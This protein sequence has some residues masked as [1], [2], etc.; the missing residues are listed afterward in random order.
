MAK[1]AKLLV[2]ELEGESIVL[3]EAARAAVE[4]T[5]E[6]VASVYGEQAYW[7]TIDLKDCTFADQQ[8]VARACAGDETLIPQ[9]RFAVAVK[10]WKKQHAG[11]DSTSILTVSEDVFA[12]LKPPALG[13]AIDRI[14]VGA[15]YPTGLK[16]SDMLRAKKQAAEASGATV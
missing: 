7:L 9:K 4:L 6:D 15:W 1:S 2:I 12:D 16:A 8:A 5:E 14:I 3:D 13:N 10:S 11:Q